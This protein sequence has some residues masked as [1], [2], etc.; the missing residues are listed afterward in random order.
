M[1]SAKLKACLAVTLSHEGV[2][3]IVR[4]DPGNWT[5]GKV[6]KG[7][8]RGTMK[9]IAASS[10]PTL[11]IKSLTDAQVATIYEREYWQP[12][13]GDSLPAG[14]DLAT[15]DYAVN[16]GVSRAAKALQRAVGARQIDGKVGSATI[17]AASDA[18]PKSV[19]N[20]ICD[21]RL[22]FLQGLTTWKTFG[23]GWGR[24]VG[25]VKA[26]ALLMAGATAAIVLASAQEETRKSATDNRTATAST[27]GG[28]GAGG[29]AAAQSGS[30]DWIALGGLAVAALV[31][32]GCGIILYR[33]ASARRQ[34]AAAMVAAVKQG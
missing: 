16:S 15:F 13:R 18:D 12:V 27:T 28:V 31:L 34:M 9:G 10:H 5:G 19:V 6:G 1:P 7:E 25:D 14:P 30:I 11:D 20:A 26:K 22:S 8:L 2:F 21:G 23:K 32:I 4:S 24:R 33:R 29:A 17:Y 3:S